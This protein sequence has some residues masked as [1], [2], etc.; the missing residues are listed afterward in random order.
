MKLF[1]DAV[2]LG[3]QSPFIRTP[4]HGMFMSLSCRLAWKTFAGNF[5][6]GDMYVSWLVTDPLFESLCADVSFE[7][8]KS[9]K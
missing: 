6:F 4:L 1:G 9:Y 2:E 8:S 5:N 3:Q 7:S